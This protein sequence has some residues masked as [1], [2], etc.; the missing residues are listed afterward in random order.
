M[1]GKTPP[2]IYQKCRALSCCRLWDLFYLLIVAKCIRYYENHNRGWHYEPVENQAEEG[3]ER[4]AVNGLVHPLNTVE[5]DHDHDE[6]TPPTK[7]RRNSE[8]ATAGDNSQPTAEAANR[9]AHS[10][11]TAVNSIDWYITG[12]GD[13]SRTQNEMHPP[14]NATERPP[15]TE[16]VVSPPSRKRPS[17]TGESPAAKRARKQ[18]DGPAVTAIERAV[19]QTTE[20]PRRADSAGSVLGQPHS[21]RGNGMPALT[22]QLAGEIL[23][24][25]MDSPVVAQLLVP[26]GPALARPDWERLRTVFETVPAARTDSQALLSELSRKP[27]AE[28]SEA[29]TGGLLNGAT[30]AIASA[31][32]PPAYAPE[33]T[34]KAEPDV[35]V[36]TVPRDGQPDRLRGASIAASANGAMRGAPRLAHDGNLNGTASNATPVR[37]PTGTEVKF[38]LAHGA[39]PR[40]YSSIEPK[41]E[42]PG[43]VYSDALENA[44]VEIDW[45]ADDEAQGFIQLEAG[46]TVESFFRK[47][48]D[49]VPPRLHD[50]E[51]RAVRIEHLN[52]P[53]GSGRAFNAR[54]RRGGE[55]GFKALV[56]RLRQL[57]EGHVPELMVTVEW[58][59]S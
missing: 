47:I 4:E 12:N 52:P 38:M 23:G 21:S 17:E 25:F 58:E 15:L 13:D 9:P 11:F 10:S 16:K 50:R 51:V 40:D 33:L 8:D 43:A 37:Q 2:H 6:G 56:R 26:N 3:I 18:S 7:D 32:G 34:A 44:E 54:I 31:Y 30:P 5:D 24:P 59:S 57:R 41:L 46:D 20:T 35:D 28:S 39:T 14:Q 53:P 45:W 36:E 48:D 55:A 49:E 1:K 29:V 19:M 27:I 42:T 22:G